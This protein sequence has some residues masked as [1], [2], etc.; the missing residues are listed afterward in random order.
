MFE[1][2]VDGKLLSV[3]ET[4][5]PHLL[6]V[7]A[8]AQFAQRQGLAGDTF[9]NRSRMAFGTAQLRSC[10]MESVIDLEIP[11]DR[12]FSIERMTTRLTAGCRGRKHRAI[13]FDLETVDLSVDLV[14]ELK[15]IG[16]QVH[17]PGLDMAFRAGACGNDMRGLLP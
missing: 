7:A 11:G 9:V 12:G 1:F 2:Q 5:I 16:D 3:A 6:I 4:T 15:P 17:K 14:P 8:R 13:R 10:D